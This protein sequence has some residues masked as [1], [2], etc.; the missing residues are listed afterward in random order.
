MRK[1]WRKR[2]REVICLNWKSFLAAVVLTALMLS[3]AFIPL[4]GSQTTF[5]YDPWADINDDGK[6]DAKDIGYVCRLFGKTGDPVNKTALLYNVNATLTEL[7]SRID[8]LNTSV[9]KLKSIME[10]RMPKKGYVFIPVSAFNPDFDE[11][12]NGVDTYDFIRGSVLVVLRSSRAWVDFSAF[13]NLPHQSIITNMTVWIYDNSNYQ[14]NVLLCRYNP[15]TDTTDYIASVSTYPPS[16]KPG[17][18]ILYDD[19]I[20]Y[21]IVDNSKFTYMLL[22]DFCGDTSFPGDISLRFYGALIEYEY[23]Q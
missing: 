16:A 17:K 11:M 10:A 12:D 7:L 21:P 22:V 15:Q 2:R 13:V 18:V 4:S 19:T 9:T 6:I 14:I 5:Q 1:I 23:L 20:T 3:L 8:Q